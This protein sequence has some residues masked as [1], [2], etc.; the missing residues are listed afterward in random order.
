MTE[1]LID[2]LSSTIKTKFYYDKKTT[3]LINKSCYSKF[4]NRPFPCDEIQNSNR[5][6]IVG[7][8]KN[9][10]I[11]DSLTIVYSAGLGNSDP[12]FGICADNMGLILGF[13][14]L[15][16]CINSNGIISVR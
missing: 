4:V 5:L 7:K 6:I 10:L 8:F 15:N 16:F 14:A 9:E 3:K 11:K 12:K 13:K 2:S 1:I